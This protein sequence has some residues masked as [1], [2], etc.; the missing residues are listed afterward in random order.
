LSKSFKENV[1]ATFEKIL[2]MFF[3]IET[4]MSKGV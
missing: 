4:K 1:F 2:A 3:E